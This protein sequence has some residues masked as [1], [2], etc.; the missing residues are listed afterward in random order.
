[1]ISR[2]KCKTPSSNENITTAELLGEKNGEN[3]VS[4][5]VY[6]LHL[7]FKSV[8]RTLVWSVSNFIECCAA[9]NECQVGRMQNLLHSYPNKFR[10][11]RLN[12]KVVQRNPHRLR[13]DVQFDEC[14]W[15]A[16]ANERKIKMRERI[17]SQFMKRCCVLQQSAMKISTH[18]VRANAFA[19]DH[20]N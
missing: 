13:L 6:Y 18:I 16:R 14:S 4:F 15:N 19:F 10:F 8:S 5:N 3:P 1:M 11:D 20:S 9:A 12:R 17:Y 2:L 7:I